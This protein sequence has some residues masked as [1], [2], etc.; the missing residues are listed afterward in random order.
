MRNNVEIRQRMEKYRTILLV[1]NWIL[2]SVIAISGFSLT[3][4]Q[5]IG[6]GVL[7]FGIIIGVIGHFLI[8]VVLAIP[9]ILLNNGDILEQI[10]NSNYS[11]N[12]GPS[13]DPNSYDWVCKK[14]NNTNRKTALFCNSCGE[15]K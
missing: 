1:F 6:G 9:F 10:K 12:I 14:C 11:S 4:A 8:N 2:A 7:F 5:G 15:K 3:G 13:N